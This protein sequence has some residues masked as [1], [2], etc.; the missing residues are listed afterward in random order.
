MFLFLKP[1]HILTQK[2][3]VEIML[4]AAAFAFLEQGEGDQS[5]LKHKTIPH[6]Q[7]FV[8]IIAAAAS[9]PAPSTARGWSGEALYD[10]ESESSLHGAALLN[11]LQRTGGGGGIG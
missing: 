7:R 8:A 3:L 11:N 1:D 2:Y 9:F 6:L 10:A 5:Q 4:V